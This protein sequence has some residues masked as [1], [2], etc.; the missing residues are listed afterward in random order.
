[1]RNIVRSE[2]IRIWRPSFLYGGIGVMA[3]FAALVSVFIYVSAPTTTAATAQQPGPAAQFAATVAQIAQPGGFL[4]ALAT[5]STLAGIILLA[6]W[7]LSAASDYSTGVIRILVQAEPKRIKLLTGKMAALLLFTLFA[8]VNTTLIVVLVARPLAR[9]QG[10]Q[11]QAWK[12]DFFPH[13]FSGYANFTIAAI[14]WGLIGLALAVLTRS[15]ALAI[16]I[17]VGYLLVVEN[18]IGIIAPDATPYLPGGTLNALVSGGTTELAWLPAL[19]LTLLYG[20]V[21]ASISLVAFHRRDII[22]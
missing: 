7:A 17:G 2:L 13:L 8:T 14:V 9:L 3:G 4:T 18:L 12:T 22:S 21:A 1:M 20:A 16:G 19:G 11:T 5:V 10:I 15:S 6:L